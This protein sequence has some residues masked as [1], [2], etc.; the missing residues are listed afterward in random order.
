MRSVSLA[1]LPF[2]RLNLTFWA[3]VGLVALGVRFAVQQDF[4]KALAFTLTAEPLA[5]LLSLGFHH[6]YRRLDAKLTETH[7]LQIST[8]AWIILASLFGAVVLGFTSHL[9]SVAAGWSEF[10]W[11][12]RETILLR[13]LTMWLILLCWSLAYFWLR[14]E[15]ALNLENRLSAQALAELRRMEFQVASARLDPHFLFNCLNGIAAEIDPRP[16]AAKAMIESLSAYLRYSLDYHKVLLGPLLDELDAMEAFLQIQQTRYGQRFAYKIDAAPSSLQR[17]V[18]CFLLQ[19]LLENA[20]KH[21]LDRQ[22]GPATISISAR[23]LEQTLHLVITSPGELRPPN[24]HRQ[25]IGLDILRRRL[26]LHYPGRHEFSLEE[27]P[28]CVCAILRL[29]GEPC[30]G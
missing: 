1:H 25:G 14:A 26:A 13:I 24:P 29:K 6:F 16:E 23:T 5:L 12:H 2:W 15:C 17:I 20:V 27:Q 4:G 21:G 11:T 8:T 3:L 7:S 9:L 22:A 18:P 28:G 10:P 19:P 30:S